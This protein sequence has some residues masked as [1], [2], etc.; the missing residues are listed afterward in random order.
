MF[1]LVGYTVTTR[2]DVSILQPDSYLGY[3]LSIPLSLVLEI[4]QMF[5]VQ[6]LPDAKQA[7]NMDEKYRAGLGAGF[8]CTLMLTLRKCGGTGFGGCRWR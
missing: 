3:Q 4:V 2:Q 1:L 8:R 7:K 5:I 6:Q